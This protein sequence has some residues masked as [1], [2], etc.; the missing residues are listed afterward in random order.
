M[1]PPL[2][3]GRVPSIVQPRAGEDRL[4]RE[5]DAKAV[6]GER[7]EN[8]Q[9][10]ERRPRVP[11]RRVRCQGKRQEVAEVI[12]KDPSEEAEAQKDEDEGGADDEAEGPGNQAT[13][14][15]RRHGLD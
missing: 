11:G 5:R 4:A 9:K 1:S 6:D 3:T 7:G 2:R 10:K 15:N 14:E 12:G 13:G 8:E